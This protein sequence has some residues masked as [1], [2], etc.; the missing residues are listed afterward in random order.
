MDWK[1][2]LLK[3]LDALG[4]KL[5]V[6]G[7]H[8]WSVLVRQAYIEGV[9]DLVVAGLVGIVFV[10]A[11]CIGKKCVEIVNEGDSDE[12]HIVVL[13]VSV[14][15]GALCAVAIWY[16]VVSGLQELLNPEFFALKNVI[17]SL[18]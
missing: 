15:I 1:Q 11:F 9:T 7:A 6:A 16:N 3:R 2:E 10:V 5:G 14:L 17:D 4:D 12:I 13:M 18:K 8:L